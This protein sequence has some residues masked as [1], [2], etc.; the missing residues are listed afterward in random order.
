MLVRKLEKA[1]GAER[2]LG[3]PPAPSPHLWDPACCTA[4]SRL[5]CRKAGQAR[6]WELCRSPADLF[7]RQDPQDVGGW[8]PY[9]DVLRI[10]SEW[11]RPVQGHT[12]WEPSRPILLVD[13]SGDA[14]GLAP[15]PHLSLRTS[16][17]PG[18]GL[19]CLPASPERLSPVGFPR[20]RDAP[21]R[22][23]PPQLRTAVPGGWDRSAGLGLMRLPRERGR[24]SCRATPRAPQR[25]KVWR[26]GQ[27]A[28]GQP[29]LALPRLSSRAEQPGWGR[30]RSAKKALHFNES[31]LLG[32]PLSCFIRCT[33][34]ELI[35]QKMAG[36]GTDTSLRGC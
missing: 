33:I 23:L 10:G 21:L 25:V 28:G 27:S 7:G 22:P 17:A 11:L 24:A 34:K 16:E 14:W 1:N 26:L 9:P 2:G 31:L 18:G 15:H 6:G 30:A 36:Q 32:R 8:W 5:P 29:R 3:L 35:R 12:R 19:G 4:S 20:Q 13:F